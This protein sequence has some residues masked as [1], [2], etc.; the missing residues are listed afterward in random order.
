VKLTKELQTT[1]G[2]ISA[3]TEKKKFSDGGLKNLSINSILR[4]DM[5]T[6]LP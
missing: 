6:L 1:K 2:K 4:L 5:E 3:R